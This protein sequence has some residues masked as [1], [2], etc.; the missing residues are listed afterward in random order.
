MRGM[1][2]AYITG[3][4][5]YLPGDPVDN[6]EPRAVSAGRW[7]TVA[8]AATVTVKPPSGALRL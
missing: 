2:D 5:A 4:G 7:P 6:E 3:V 1:T 8:G